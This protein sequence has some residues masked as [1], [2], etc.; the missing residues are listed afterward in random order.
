MSEK[1]PLVPYHC[2]AR[3]DM[4][5]FQKEMN[6]LYDIGYRLEQ[7]FTSLHHNPDFLS[8][9]YYCAVMKHKSFDG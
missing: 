3:K 6:R 8:E 4:I 9:P 2:F 7:A 5:E 1:R